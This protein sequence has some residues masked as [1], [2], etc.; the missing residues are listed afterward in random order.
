MQLKDEGQMADKPSGVSVQRKRQSG[1]WH[2][3]GSILMLLPT[4]RPRRVITL[5]GRDLARVSVSEALQRDW[6]KVLEGLPSPKKDTALH[7]TCS[8]TDS[9]RVDYQLTAKP[10]R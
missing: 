3:F 7:A 9:V 6:E 10:S 8:P 4:K 2:G 5:D 1:F